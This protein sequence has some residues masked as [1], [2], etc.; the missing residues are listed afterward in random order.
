[1]D[2]SVRRIDQDGHL[3][4][5]LS[6]IS[7]ANVC[8]YL[9][10]EIPDADKHGLKPD[11]I[12]QLYRH[13]DALKKSAET[14]N[15]K[16]LLI[17]HKPQ[18]ADEH[19]HR[20]VVGSV[21]NVAFDA[22]Y[23]QAELVVW[24]GD[25]IKLIES[26]D[27]RELSCGY[28]YRF[29]PEPGVADGVPYDGYM[30]DIVGNH[31]ALV[32][33]GRAGHDVFVGDAKP[34]PEP[35]PE[36]CTEALPKPQEQRMAVRHATLSRQA[37]LASG[38]LRAYLRPKLATDAK[39]DLTPILAP[40]TSKNW[41]NQKAVIKTALDKAL[42]GKLAADAE[43][44]DIIDILEE[45][46]DAV[47][48]EDEG[49]GAD[50]KEDDEDEEDKKKKAKEGAEKLK[51][52]AEDEKD[53]DPKLRPKMPK[54]ADESDD[55]DDD[56][57]SASDESDDEDDDKPVRDR[58]GAKDRKGARDKAKGMDQQ[59]MVTKTAMDAAI[60][61]AVSLAAKRAAQEAETS[62][63][64]RLRAIAA[65]E[66]AVRPYI[67]EIAVAQDSAAAVYRLALDA[68]GVDLAGVPEA[69]FPA[70]VKL[71]PKPD[72]QPK[73]APKGTRVALDSAGISRRNEMFPNANRLLTY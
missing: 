52:A 63:I 34:T 48:K 23:L 21:H 30:T 27:Q 5:E 57:K 37:L 38:A 31:V 64:A 26:G 55:E 16:P 49:L 44:S 4:V 20:L 3:H 62:T 14:F 36:V 33:E 13:P 29:V 39:I 7:K 43:I 45:L 41:L 56:K 53:D 46:D 2:Q 19:D 6:N 72:D 50:E 9:G 35:T 60:A 24:D 11:Q 42:V 17:V 58:K 25:A 67:G 22:P 54:A 40:V 8:G 65:A 51:E 10:R 68:A 18:T 71:L 61:S 15:G 66:K 32:T 70:M 47:D 12:Y 69:A 1:M 73:A 59:P 28:Y